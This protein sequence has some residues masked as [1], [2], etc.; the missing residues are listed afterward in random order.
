M[1]NRNLFILAALV[2]STVGGFIPGVFGVGVMSLWG[3]LW[4]TVG[5]VAG[6]V[7]AYRFAA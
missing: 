1:S 6:V 7:L 5:G 4:S 2:G 3:I